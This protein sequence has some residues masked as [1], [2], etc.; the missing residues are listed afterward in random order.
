M[1]SYP[2]IDPV[3][4]RIGPLA[5]RWYGLMYALSFISALFLIKVVAARKKLA[6][7]HEAISDF[8][9]YAAI[10]TILG[11]RLGYVFIYDPLFYLSHPLKVFAVWEGGMSFHGG[12]AGVIVAGALFC[13]RYR[14]AFYEMA[15]VVVVSVPIG[16]GLGRIGNFINGELFGRPTNL[17]WCMV[18]PQGGDACRHPSQIYQ[19]ALEGGL[20]FVILW[21]LSKRDLPRGVLFW[22]LSLFYGLFRFWAEFFRQPDPQ[23]GLLWGA[24]TM[25]QLLSLPMLMVGGCMIWRLY[26]RR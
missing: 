7:T 10:G 24:L 1:I 5:L 22:S 17:P 8:I 3:F 23:M 21:F 13:K 19:A 25:G 18:F 4:L 26:H 20:L 14:F 6:I 11:G 16:L 15:D 2:H 12:L 9:F